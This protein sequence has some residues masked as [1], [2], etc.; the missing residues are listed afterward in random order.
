[1]IPP[2]GPSAEETRARF[3][4]IAPGYD[5]ANSVLSFGI[6]HYWRKKLIRKAELRPGMK[7]L[8]CATGTGDLAIGIRE[9]LGYGGRGYRD[10]LLS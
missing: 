8:D 9:G 5:R 2:V 7:V 4:R 6:H 1:M 10:G 3:G